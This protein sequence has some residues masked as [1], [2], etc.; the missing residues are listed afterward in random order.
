ADADAIVRARAAQ[1]LVYCRGSDA[2]PPLIK[3]MSDKADEVRL[4]ATAALGQSGDKRAL[5]PLLAALK[6]P[7]VDVRN[8]AGPGLAQFK[9]EM[10]VAPALVEALFDPASRYAAGNITSTLKRLG[11]EV[12]PI[13]E[14]VQTVLGEREVIVGYR[15]KLPGDRDWCERR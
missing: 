4:Y 6:D 9:G 13:R 2:V 7:S 1:A 11:A 3:A 10:A 12:E 15:V 8:V 5:K 14:R